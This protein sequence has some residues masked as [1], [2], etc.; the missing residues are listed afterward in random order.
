MASIAA[1]VPDL[2]NITPEYIAYTNAPTLLAQTGALYA[3]VAVV[4]LLRC[5]V[6]IWMLQSFG[7]DDWAI[8]FAFVFATATY[9]IYVI[10]TTVGIGRHLVVIQMDK[11]RYR[12]FLRLRQTQSILVAIGVALIKVSVACFLL[13]LVTKKAYAWFLHGLNI[14][15]T[16]FT[17][18]CVGTLAA[19][20]LRLRPPPLGSGTAK[21]FNSQTFT[22]IGLMN[23]IVT[24]A[25]DFLL[26]LL[27]IPLIWNLQLNIRT[28]VSLILVLALG[29]F[30]GIACVIKSKKQAKFFDNPDPYVYDTFTMWR[31][32]EFDVGIIAASLPALKPLFSQFLNASRS[33]TSAQIKTSSF[34]Q[35]PNTLGYHKQTEHSD[36]GIM[37][38]EYN[39]RPNNSVRVSCQSMGGANNKMWNMGR[40]TDSDES[41][42]PLHGVM[43]TPNAIVVR[44]D[45]HVD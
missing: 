37:L 9:I 6:R 42:L 23:T 45:V 27:P 7:K 31:F 34:H 25:T 28:R 11:D 40:S 12:E 18:A 33:L 29:L 43:N 26:A 16:L 39:T 14:F 19:W 35:N 24:I 1:G 2:S 30:A 10:Q 17:A 5:Y 44:R 4:V 15:M 13:R 32:I 8:L 41:I 3:A 20:D 38:K 21:C 22:A 36:K